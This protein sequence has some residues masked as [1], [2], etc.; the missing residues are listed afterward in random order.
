MPAEIVHYERFAHL[1]EEHIR[2]NPL[3]DLLYLAPDALLIQQARSLVR[4]GFIPKMALWREFLHRESLAVLEPGETLLGTDIERYMLRKVLAGM[5][6]FKGIAR[7]EGAC[8]RFKEIFS[9]LT[10]NPGT[11]CTDAAVQEA[12]AR[13]QKEKSRARRPDGYDLFSRLSRRGVL[14]P[15]SNDL[16]LEGFY[17]VTEVEWRCL[18]DLAGAT[19]GK[20]F[21]VGDFFE[22]F[23]TLLEQGIPPPSR[24]RSNIARLYRET[25]AK[26]RSAPPSAKQVYVL[27]DRLE[28][29]RA[30][31]SRLKQWIL[32]ETGRGRIP[33]LNRCVV[34]F[35][36]IQT[37]IPLVRR[38]FR[39]FGIPFHAPEPTPLSSLPFWGFLKRLL[40]LPRGP[41]RLEHLMGLM[42]SGFLPTTVG[43][44]AGGE[45]T[46][47]GAGW[48]S[49]ARAM[50]ERYSIE[51]PETLAADKQEIDLAVLARV[52]AEV[53]AVSVDLFDP[54]ERFLDRSVRFLLGEIDRAYHDRHKQR[55]KEQLYSFLR[56]YYL[57]RVL[58]KNLEPFLEAQDPSEK[59]DALFGLLRN[60]VCVGP[61]DTRSRR[62]LEHS[63]LALMELKHA[64]AVLGR[65]RDAA[66]GEGLIAETLAAALSSQ[67]EPRPPRGNEVLVTGSLATAGL[68]IQ[69]IYIGGLVEGEFPPR[70]LRTFKWEL[71]GALDPIDNIV[72]SHYLLTRFVNRIPHI[73]FFFPR[74]DRD[75]PLKKSPFLIDAGFVETRGPSASPAPRAGPQGVSLLDEGT[76]Y[77]EAGSALRTAGAVGNPAALALLPAYKDDPKRLENVVTMQ[78][79]RNDPGRFSAYEGVIGPCPSLRGLLRHTFSVTALEDLAACPMKYHFKE[80]LRLQR[81]ELPAPG[82]RATRAGSLLHTILERFFSERDYQPVR[83]QGLSEAAELLRRIAEEEFRRVAG[84]HEYSSYLAVDRDKLVSGLSDNGPRGIL[85]AWLEQEA[86][87]GMLFSPARDIRGVPGIEFTYPRPGERFAVGG[88]ELAGRID[89]IDVHSNADFYAVFDYKKGD[90]PAPALMEARL[91][92]QLPTYAYYVERTTGKMLLFGGYI[93]FKGAPSY[94]IQLLSLKAD[95]LDSGPLGVDMLQ[96]YGIVK[97]SHKSRASLRQ[98]G[99]KAC[100]AYDDLLRDR[101]IERLFAALREAYEQGR[102]HY[103]LNDPELVCKYCEYDRICRK[104]LEKAR[105]IRPTGEGRTG[106][107]AAGLGEVP[108]PEPPLPCAATAGAPSAEGAVMTPSQEAALDLSR[109][110][111]VTAGAG[112]GKTQALVER[113]LKIFRSGVP[114]DRVLVITFTQKAA[115]EMRDRIYTSLVGEISKRPPGETAPGLTAAYEAFVDNYISTIDSFCMG[116]LK[117]F[118]D[119]ARVNPDLELAHDF[120]LKQLREEALDRHLDALAQQ[121]DE[122]VRL[123]LHK[124]P[125]PK[126]K[127]L[128]AGLVEE[129]R[130]EQWA[131]KMSSAEGCLRELCGGETQEARRQPASEVQPEAESALPWYTAF[132]GLVLECRRRYLDLKDR[133][134]FYTFAD[135]KRKVLELLESSPAALATL[136]SRFLYIMVDEFQDTDEIQWRILELLGAEKP[137]GCLAGDKIFLVGDEKQ[138]I[139]RFR[140]ADLPVFKKAREELLEAN[141]RAGTSSA[142]LIL[143]DNRQHFPSERERAGDIRF[144]HNFRSDGNLVAFFNDFF[145]WLFTETD[146]RPFHAAPEP[147]TAPRNKEGRGTVD[148]HIVLQGATGDGQQAEFEL[149]ACLARDLAAAWRGHSTALLIRSRTAL[150]QLE[151]ALQ[152]AGVHYRVHGGIGYYQS[153]EVTDLWLALA[154]ITNPHDDMNLVG[155]LRSPLMGLSDVDIWRI[156]ASRTHPGQSL[157]SA[158]R[159]L[160]Q[161]A[162]ACAMLDR[163]VRLKKETT[164]EELLERVVEESGYLLPSLCAPGWEQRLANIEKLFDIA[165]AFSKVSPSLESFVGY[166]DGQI[167]TEVREQDNPVHVE[168]DAPVH[169]MTIHAAKGLQFSTVILADAFRAVR[170]DTEPHLVRMDDGRIRVAFKVPRDMPGQ[171]DIEPEYFK[172][173]KECVD[174]QI[175]AETKR[176]LYVALTRAIHNVIIVGSDR[177]GHSGRSSLFR[178]WLYRFLDLPEKLDASVTGRRTVKGVRV[179]IHE[180]GVRFLE[181]DAGRVHLPSWD[182]IRAVAENA[183]PITVRRVEPDRT[184]VLTP[185]NREHASAI[186]P[187]IVLEKAFIPF[188]NAVRPREP[189]RDHPLA[190][191]LS[192]KMGEIV[193]QELAR[194]HWDERTM[195]T[196]V[197]SLAGQLLSPD[198]VDAATAALLEHVENVRRS[199]LWGLIER[200]RQRY[201]ELDF[202]LFRDGRLITGTIDLLCR[203][204]EGWRIYD[205]KTVTASSE[206]EAAQIVREHGYDDQIKAYYWAVTELAGEEPLSASIVLTGWG[207]CE[208]TRRQP[209]PVRPPV[210]QCP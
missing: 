75:G 31:A 186:A 12:Y 47:T 81:L 156:A 203:F 162:A 9:L 39:E 158:M 28:E 29:V 189:W 145:G 190:A 177:Q 21:W 180:P 150:E 107:A 115:R 17:W 8:R 142:P 140:G 137:G 204:E 172:A 106:A 119:H 26:L 83:P 144:S 60:L 20:V 53:S 168:E 165:S 125:H 188:T 3:P 120:L 78:A 67:N 77:R 135:L 154:C 38:I 58:M 112:S 92:L 59:I 97:K 74:A 181:E 44:S 82:L 72:Q 85:R 143:R 123:L 19:K 18:A 195:R 196:A 46:D 11:R 33:D 193:H 117:E 87:H 30:V 4:N 132:A 1:Y 185:S 62:A 86:A 173:A 98:D 164:I 166:L 210:R 51:L 148:L 174:R 65:G 205:W 160:D 126:L 91:N 2:S 198:L 76:L 182:A 202:S 208:M 99:E 95:D 32:E 169:V 136:R 61:E 45:N 138:S 5:S 22:E 104:D 191:T 134:G 37:Y 56:Q 139:F 161:C 70:R 101:G 147:M 152:K 40:D 55:L 121:G 14:C 66:G 41:L 102:F 118:A 197:S 27:P 71:V 200:A 7:F 133:H 194:M 89:R 73:E 124:W 54:E 43:T 201:H 129:D 155:L 34:F 6:E 16:A 199:P 171:K 179:M 93:S 128:V 108:T 96:H 105:R 84:Y 79:L 103:T 94:S 90:A 23:V 88:F 184:T 42:E 24:I 178:K 141:Q 64:L 183:P 69:R 13:Y 109:N 15:G 153:S 187:D 159:G 175:E 116:V 48:G 131:S 114:V 68:D 206:S 52:A 113:A 157:F 111:V 100:K 49:F 10:L 209:V 36:D 80:H 110:I 192:R 57:L 146:P 207:V 25:L 127:D 63:V 35:Y 50:C 176:L 130:V 163:W 122:R 167:R 151:R 149:A 170:A